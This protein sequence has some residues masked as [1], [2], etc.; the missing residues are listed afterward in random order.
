MADGFGNDDNLR[1]RL[2]T[3][4]GTMIIVAV[5]ALAGMFLITLGMQ[6]YEDV[7]IASDSNFELRTSLSYLAT[8]IRETDNSG[9]V[10]VRS[11][12]GVDYLI[13]TEMIDGEPVDTCI[14]YQ[15]GSLYEYLT[16]S[17]EEPDPSFG[18]KMM[19][20]A[21]L[22]M[23]YDGSAVILSA[24][25]SS[26]KRESLTVYLRSDREEGRAHD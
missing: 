20:I 15:N 25:N 21:E 26:G 4:F 19:D 17:G 8:R 11:Y 1:G 7:V 5:F 24:Y 14:Y 18:F 10:H 3:M 12:D 22:S 2:T 6:V 16:V 13:L 23:R 9:M